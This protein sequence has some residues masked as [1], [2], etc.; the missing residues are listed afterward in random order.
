MQ[1]SAH[2]KQLKNHQTKMGHP[3]VLIG[4]V[5]LTVASIAGSVAFADFVPLEEMKDLN[6]M[7]RSALSQD[8]RHISEQSSGQNTSEQKKMSNE[9]KTV[10]SSDFKSIGFKSLI[11]PKLSDCFNCGEI[12]A[13]EPMPYTTYGLNN[14][15]NLM[16][17]FGDYLD[18]HRDITRMVSPAERKR[19]VATHEMGEQIKNTYLIK[20]R[21]HNGT[22]YT[23]TQS[24][25]PQ[26]SVG[27]TIRVITDKTIAA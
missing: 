8:N 7:V 10:P 4:A 26:K 24:S 3:I 9:N 6:Q 5:I 16:N 20:V 15:D 2:N 27:D 13:I 18:A 23:L 17:Q 11:N 12:I 19:V 14:T 1:I 22:E 21:M 25:P